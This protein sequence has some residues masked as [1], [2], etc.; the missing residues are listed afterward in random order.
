MHQISNM[1]ILIKGNNF[2]LDQC[3]KK[4]KDIVQLN[5]CQYLNFFKK[6]TLVVL[7]VD[8]DL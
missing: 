1:F 8:L 2:F 5:L 7:L 6:K 4:T 3:G